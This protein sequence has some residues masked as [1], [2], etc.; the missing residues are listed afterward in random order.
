MYLIGAA[1]RLRVRLHVH[2]C[3]LLCDGA[4]TLTCA[5]LPQTSGRVAVEVAVEV[6]NAEEIAKDKEQEEVRDAGGED[7]AQ[8]LHTPSYGQFSC[9]FACLAGGFARLPLSWS[10]LR[11]RFEKR[12]MREFV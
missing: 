9:L 12:Q 4:A 8:V 6:A 7:D 2:S 10:H 1:L 5:E 11:K 3:R